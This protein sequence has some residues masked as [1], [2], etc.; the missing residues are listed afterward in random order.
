[1]F[2]IC[3]SLLPFCPFAPMPLCLFALL[4]FCPFALIS[5]GQKRAKRAKRAKKAKWQ[6]G[7]RANKKGKPFWKNMIDAVI[8]KKR[9]W[10]YSKIWPLT[11]RCAVA[12]GAL[13]F[14]RL[15][16]YHWCLFGPLNLAN[17]WKAVN[18]IRFKMGKFSRTQIRTLNS[19]SPK[20]KKIFF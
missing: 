12:R 15:T 11:L 4:P 13:K 3:P 2:R 17:L 19:F 9:L 5:K 18:R 14:F 6:K 8:W 1:M 20:K 7:K 10:S 16:R